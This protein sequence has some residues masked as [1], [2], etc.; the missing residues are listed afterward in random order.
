MDPLERDFLAFWSR[1]K[2]FDQ[3]QQIGK[4][5]GVFFNAGE[6]RSWKGEG[7]SATGFEDGD[8]VLVPL[9]FMLRPESR[10]AVQKIVGLDG[11]AL[12]PGYRKGAKEMVVDL[13]K[14]T[15][16]EFKAFVEKNR[17]TNLGG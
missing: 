8:N 15:P 13:G 10:E 5:M 2:E 9:T 7:G 3:M 11:L 14:V 12:P 16:E 4:L 1:E 17:V 6:V